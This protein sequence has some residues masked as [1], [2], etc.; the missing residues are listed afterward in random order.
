M[1]LV[2]LPVNFQ[3]EFVRGKRECDMELIWALYCCAGGELIPAKSLTQ[4]LS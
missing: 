3:L 4:F 1:L 2:Y